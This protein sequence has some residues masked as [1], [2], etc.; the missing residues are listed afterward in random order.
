MAASFPAPAFSHRCHLV[1][2]AGISVR[3]D[4]P[5]APAPGRA[6]ADAD[7]DARTRC[8]GRRRYGSMIVF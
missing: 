5:V 8:A 4:A 1:A 6:A 3:D 2:S 7:A